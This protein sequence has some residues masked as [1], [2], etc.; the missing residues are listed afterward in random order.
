MPVYAL[1]VAKH[2]SRL[3]ESTGE[4]TGIR[5]GRGEISGGKVA[6]AVLARILSSRVGRPILDRTGLKGN[7]DFK[8]EWTPDAAEPMKGGPGEK[9]EAA[10]AADLSGPSIFTALQEQLGLKLEATK[11]PVD[12][13]IIDRAEKPTE[14]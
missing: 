12:I 9:A 8:L 11:A 6:I 2:G 13:I 14:N 10:P 3:K 1:V 7:Y 5:A 4:G